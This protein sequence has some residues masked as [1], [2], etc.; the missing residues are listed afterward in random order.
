LHRGNRDGVDTVMTVSSAQPSRPRK[1]RRGGRSP[2]I[3]GLPQLTPELKA[4]IR[5]LIVDDDDT[6]RES[7]ASV[8]KYDGYQVTACSRGEEARNLLKRNKF[9]IA[10]FDLYLPEISGLTL[11]R[12][13][14]D[15][16]PD[17]MV[18]MITGN[19]SVESSLEALRSGAWDYLPKPFSGTHLQILLGRAAHAVIV[20]RESHALQ[21]SFDRE[22]GNSDLVTVL[23]SAPGFRRAMDMARR[24]AS[25]DASVFITGESGSGKELIAQFIHRH[26]RRSSRPLIALNCA[27]LPESLLESEMF[28]HVKGAFTGAVRDKP[29]LLETAN[30]GT[31]LLD[32]LAEMSKPIQAKLLRAVQDGVV[33]R[34]GSETTDAVVNVR[35]IASTNRNPEE[36]VAAGLLRH[37]LYYRLR[38]VPIHLPPLRERP[39]DVKLL[40]EHFLVHYWGRHRGATAA[41]PTFSDAA[42]RA[43]RARP[44]QGNVR[45]LQNVIEHL[46]VLLDPG[47]EIHPDDIPAVG[48]GG[49]AQGTSC[50]IPCEVTIDE[51]YYQARDRLVAEFELQYLTQLINRVRGNM[52]RAAR[53]ANVD[54]TS[55]YR[56]LE[57]HGLHRRVPTP[58][59]TSD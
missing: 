35:F 28:G 34:V 54:R 57:R 27:A 17:T 33:R 8:L 38:V 31:L 19:P 5:I 47:T 59:A 43:L 4:S 46:V 21:A 14:V 41:L 24:V 11:L 29:G 37:D 10:I 12:K 53:V 1:S 55:L 7:C 45:E 18:I 32:E 22:N 51:P 6:L 15:A 23:G 58:P 40:A 9:D 20:A 39:G 36:A 26:S 25:T 50:T 44:W 48:E 49:A 42:I 30:G 2:E 52:S 13:C 56:L 3:I 16:Y